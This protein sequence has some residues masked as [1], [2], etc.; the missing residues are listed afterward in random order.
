MVGGHH[1]AAAA[2]GACFQLTSAARSII[3]TRTPIF[4]VLECNLDRSGYQRAMQFS[5]H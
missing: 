2:K 3:V 4:V 5:L 1:V